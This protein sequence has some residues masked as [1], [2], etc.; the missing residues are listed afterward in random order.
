MSPL[1]RLTNPPPSFL[2]GLVNKCKGIVGSFTISPMI[3]PEDRTHDKEVQRAIEEDVLA[4]KM[5]TLGGVSDMLYYG[6]LLLSKD[7]KFYPSNIPL[8]IAHGDTDNL[9]SPEASRDFIDAVMA[10]SKQLK[11]Y[12]GA[13]H[14]LFMEAGELKYEVARDVISWLDNVLDTPAASKL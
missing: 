4:S 14:E 12:P 10:R 3:N 11:T 2:I 9:N 8:L 6:S 1:I 13:R 7:Y 5:A